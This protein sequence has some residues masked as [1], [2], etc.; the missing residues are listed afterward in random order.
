MFFTFSGT[1]KCLDAN[2]VSMSGVIS[3][4]SNVADRD[5]LHDQ[6]K[7]DDGL[8]DVG[9]IPFF[10]LPFEFDLQTASP[11]EPLGAITANPSGLAAERTV[12]PHENGNMDSRNIRSN[13][14]AT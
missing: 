6:D 3:N 1:T 11:N 7:D 5:N 14:S 12:G 10:T 13:G 9:E 8:P 2:T 4:W